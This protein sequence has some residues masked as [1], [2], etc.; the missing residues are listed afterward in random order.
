[1]KIPVNDIFPEQARSTQREFC[2]ESS[3]QADVTNDTTLESLI[4]E[5]FQNS[6]LETT[7]DANTKYKYPQLHQSSAEQDSC[8]LY[9]Q[10][11]QEDVLDV[12]HRD[13]RVMSVTHGGSYMPFTKSPSLTSLVI[14]P[15]L[16][17]NNPVVPYQTPNVG[18]SMFSEH[19]EALETQCRY[20]LD[21]AP[22]ALSRGMYVI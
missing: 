16:F 5:L 12:A 7:M 11:S 2:K 17:P 1:M 14:P 21:M 22:D 18:Q 3:Y 13:N 19:I 6:D 4:G 9:D 8:F 15:G 10:A 20:K